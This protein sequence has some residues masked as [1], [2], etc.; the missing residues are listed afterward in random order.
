MKDYFSLKFPEVH[1]NK[2]GLGSGPKKHFLKVIRI[3][4]RQGRQNRIAEVSTKEAATSKQPG[5]ST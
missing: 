4:Y 3:E 1:L 5:N 2:Y